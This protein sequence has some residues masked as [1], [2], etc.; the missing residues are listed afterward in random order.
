[1]GAL[2]DV[3][4]A[5]ALDG[6]FVH[7]LGQ[8]AMAVTVRPGTPEDGNPLGVTT[9]PVLR[10]FSDAAFIVLLSNVVGFLYHWAAGKSANPE[11]LTYTGVMIGA[12]YVV[13]G[14]LTG[15][16]GWS[17]ASRF[18][19]F[20]DAVKCWTIAFAVLWFLLFAFKAGEMFSRGSILTFYLGCLPVVGFW[21]VFTDPVIRGLARRGTS[22]FS[23]TRRSQAGSFGLAAD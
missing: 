6:D 14:R 7:R 5:P 23:Y 9:R 11:E 3:L 20:K 12:T 2:P 21:R 15:R 17:G 18:R 19:A 13:A 4:D 8:S 22:C 16:A 10:D 1:M